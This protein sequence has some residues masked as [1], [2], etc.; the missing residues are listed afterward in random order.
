[1]KKLLLSVILLITA[2]NCQVAQLIPVKHNGYY[3]KIELKIHMLATSAIGYDYGFDT[4]LDINYVYPIRDIDQIIENIDSIT[5]KDRKPVITEEPQLP[6]KDNKQ[7]AK[8]GKQSTAKTTIAP[9]V[10]EKVVEPV[11]ENKFTAENLPKISKELEKFSDQDLYTYYI[12]I[13]RLNEMMDYM[14]WYCQKHKLWKEYN[15]IR[16]NWS[17]PMKNYMALLDAYYLKN[18]EKIYND[19]QPQRED[20]KK[21][22]ILYYQKKFTI[23][24]E[25]N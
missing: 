21:N 9:P 3:S 6:A 20:I 5:Y 23:V 10:E 15:Q 16:I 2:V 14:L 11:I 22:A 18:K 1:M 13:C 17:D 25:Y 7:Q 24:D 12:K 19:I 4:H 8:S